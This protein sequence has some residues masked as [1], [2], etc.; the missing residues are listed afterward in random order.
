MAKKKDNIEE[1][2]QEIQSDLEKEEQDTAKIDEHMQ[3]MAY[4]WDKV[5]EKLRK[6]NTCFHTKKQL[7]AEGQDPKDVKIH[8][9][10]ANQTDPGI[11]AFVSVSDE[12]IQELKTK[13]EEHIKESVGEDK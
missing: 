1:E 8:I 7:V 9:L 4:L 13:Q 5:H 10:E 3:Q 2:L 6:D 12:A 11:V